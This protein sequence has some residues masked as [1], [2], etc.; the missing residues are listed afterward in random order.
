MK[1]KEIIEI[2]NELIVAASLLMEN[3]LLL[4]RLE[5]EEALQSTN[6][7]F[8]FSAYPVEGPQLNVEVKT[9]NPTTQDDWEKFKK[10]RDNGR[11]PDNMNL[12]IRQNGLGGEL[13]HNWFAA[14][15]RMLEYTLETE[16]KI[17]ESGKVGEKFLLIFCGDGW[18]WNQDHLTDFVTFYRSGQHRQ[19]DLFAKMEK[20]E[21]KKNG[22]QI[23]NTIHHFGYFERYPLFA[24]PTRKI[25]DIK[26]TINSSFPTICSIT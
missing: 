1:A 24:E 22:T 23:N 8:D 2:H 12:I 25:W 14:R 26:P 21:M 16:Q 10:I 9:I 20:F 17:A 11:L 5:Y 13:W 18:K 15:S 19:G 6:K 7:R 4:T 3:G